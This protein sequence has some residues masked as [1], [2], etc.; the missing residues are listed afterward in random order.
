MTLKV[1]GFNDRNVAD[2]GE[3]GRDVVAMRVSQVNA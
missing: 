2:S 1:S 3:N